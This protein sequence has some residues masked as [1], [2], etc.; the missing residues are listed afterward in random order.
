[1]SIT[2]ST[3]Y[4]NINISMDAVAALAGGVVTE[5]YGV[6]GMASQK[7][8]KDGIAELLKKEN[9]T[10][11]IVVRNTDEGLELDMYII[12]SH[13]VKISEVVREVQQRVK[14]MLEK[15]L[16]LDFRQVNVYVQDVKVMK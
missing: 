3:Q 16:E 7:I 15:T 14:Y 9:Y 6:V 11:G 2:K 10:K 4:G 1:M 13:G 5:C 12:V 8:L